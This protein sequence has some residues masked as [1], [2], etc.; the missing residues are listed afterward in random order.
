MNFEQVKGILERALTVGVTWLVAKGFVP[1]SISAELVTFGLL[2]ASLVWG[3]VVN[4]P[5]VLADA[6]EKTAG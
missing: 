2:V 6:A 3:W 5:S 4:R 1:A